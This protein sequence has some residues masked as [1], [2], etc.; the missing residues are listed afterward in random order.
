MFKGECDDM[1]DKVFQ[2]FKNSEN[3]RQFVN[4]CEAL[5]R[6]IDNNMKYLGEMN[7]F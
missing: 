3:K 4:N 2:K 6:Y 5:W 7:Q 1:K